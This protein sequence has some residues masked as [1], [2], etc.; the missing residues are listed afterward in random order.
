MVFIKLA[1]VSLFIVMAA[2]GFHSDNLTPFSPARLRRHRDRG[3][4]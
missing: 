3:R 1:I 4:A 2:T